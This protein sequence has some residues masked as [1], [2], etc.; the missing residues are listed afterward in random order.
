MKIFPLILDIIPDNNLHERGLPRTV[1][2]AKGMNFSPFDLKV[3]L[4]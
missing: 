3:K 4:F 2:S 1:L